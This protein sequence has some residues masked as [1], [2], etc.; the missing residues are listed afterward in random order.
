[1]N[2]SRSRISLIL[3]ITMIVL[4]ITVSVS[5][6]VASVNTEAKMN[7]IVKEIMPLNTLVDNLLID[8][9]NME[10]GLRGYELSGEKLFLEPHIKGRE[11]L[12]KD[13]TQI[14]AFQQ[15]YEW[16]DN[17]MNIEVKPIIQL[18]LEHYDRQIERVEQ[19][20]TPEALQYVSN[21][22]RHM[23]RFR[24]VHDWMEVEIEQVARNAQAAAESA[25]K[26]ARLIIAIGGI[27]AVLTSMLSLFIFNRA[28]KAEEQLRRSEETYRYMAESLEA[29]NE[30]IITQ[31]E[32]QETTLEKL[33]ERES[34]LESISAFQTKLSG[35]AQLD[36]FLKGSMPALLDAL[37]LDAAM[38]VVNVNSSA[39][40]K[41]SAAVASSAE[42]PDEHLLE[43]L[44]AIGYPNQL[45]SLRMSELYGAARR[46]LVEKKPLEVSRHVSGHE[47]GV[48]Q[49]IHRAT[50]YYYPLLN[51]QEES[52]GFLLMTSYQASSIQSRIRYAEGLLRQFSLAFMVQQTNEERR[53]QAMELGE[54]N[55]Q[56]QQEKRLIEEQRDMIEG[57]L[58]STNEGMLMCDGQGS[59]LFTNARMDEITGNSF[60]PGESIRSWFESIL[61][62]SQGS[63]LSSMKVLLSSS[64]NRSTERLSFV[65]KGQTS[66]RHIELYAAKVGAE[67]SK[68]ASNGYLFVV[69]DRTEE[70]RIDELKNEFISIVSH[71]LRTP[72]ASVL[73][74]IEIMLHREQTPEKRQKYLQTVYREATRLSTLIN[75]FL[76]LQRMESGKQQYQYTPVELTSLLHNVSEQWKVGQQHEL[77]LH[78]PPSEVWIQGDA[79]RLMQ[80]LHNLISNAMKYSPQANSIDV[81][82]LQSGDHVQI[83]VQ[84]YGLGIPEE[85]RGK[86]FS[87][88]YRVDN[89][90]RRQIGGTGL[91]LAIVREI[92]EAHHGTVEFESVM[93][94]GTTFIVTLQIYEAA[95]AADCIL[96]LE[97]DDNLAQLIQETLS[98]LPHP[99]V[100][101]RSAEEGLQALE[102]ADH[103]SPKLCIVDIQLEGVLNGWEFISRLYASPFGDTPVVVSTALEPP[104]S[105]QETDSQKFLCKP[106]SMEKLLQ[107][108]DRLLKQPHVQPTVIFP[109][110]DS[111]LLERELE[112]Q[113]IAVDAIKPQ[114][115]QIEVALK[116]KPEP[117]E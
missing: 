53:R 30:E 112:Q 89:S 29:Q 23:D 37:K 117:N 39:A 113:G 10:T 18:L 103:T 104:S 116:P 45:P 36:T 5:S 85:A 87:K 92:V 78:I 38:L 42:A 58:E 59:I 27:A 74:F 47:S 63:P 86:L 54:L 15:R 3:L 82:L 56:L 114:S 70:E 9:I 77:R 100:R 12:Q 68:N 52:I 83:R 107:V 28:R 43:T 31:Q 19:G 101:V 62:D 8:L 66:K 51:D 32:E 57:I 72:L 79:D 46:V 76:D 80:V 22:K 40:W 21:G 50:D 91:G 16:L 48:H 99:V 7:T 108:V 71:E 14:A 1:M 84:D 25:E 95:N 111:A 106:F 98:Q 61:D 88:F 60:K 11:Q 90:D 49:G 115:D 93:G 44:Y 20:R 35:A 96:L 67:D 6:Y 4:L 55:A 65:P 64:M 109:P 81:S 2:L 105:Y 94:E 73:G 97:D 41:Q 17:Y 110:Q 33:S 102:R 75:D 26:T 24:L 34:E 69:R 13:L